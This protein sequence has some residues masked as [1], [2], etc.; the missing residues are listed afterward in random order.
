M[1]KAKRKTSKAK[2]GLNKVEK[3]QVS[4]IAKKAVN[5]IAESKYMATVANIAK[6]VPNPIWKDGLQVSEISCLGYATGRALSSAYVGSAVSIKYGV[7]IVD[8][9]S[10]D[11]ASLNMNKVFK[12]DDPVVARRQNAI[13][14]HS[15]RP[16][17][18][19]CQWLLERPGGAFSSEP[20]NSQPIRVRMVRVRPRPIKG[21]AQSCNPEFDLFL[22]QYNE[23]IGIS[24]ATSA[25]V[26]IFG[27]YEFE[28]SKVN[29]RRYQV[30]QDTYFT[31]SSTSVQ[32]NILNANKY[33]TNVISTS[34]QK[35]LKTKHNIGKEL[36]YT[37]PNASEDN[38]Y[39]QSGFNPEFILFHFQTMGQPLSIDDRINTDNICLT[40]RPVSTFKDV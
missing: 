18:A 5:S 38:S 30:L 31:M 24:S 13:Q 16:S 37:S 3:K 20:T 33:E 34:G 39:P 35:K 11:M 2:G 21:S 23:S 25:G 17:F 29:N 7:S 12:D 26:S 22:D 8:G 28:M 6:V 14:G 10:I 9:T 40:A 15:V 27:Q 19:E 32:N 36:Y 1:A 4:T